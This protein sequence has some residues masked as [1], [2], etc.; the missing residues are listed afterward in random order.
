MMAI[1]LTL[2]SAQ[3]DLPARTIRYQP[4]KVGSIFA[5][6]KENRLMSRDLDS[7]DSQEETFLWK[8]RILTSTR[9]TSGVR[10]SME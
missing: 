4:H 2:V 3:L 6:G 1:V 8:V 10:E 7:P 5:A 9:E